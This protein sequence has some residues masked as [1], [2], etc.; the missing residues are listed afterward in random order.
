MIRAGGIIHAAGVVGFA[1]AFLVAPTRAQTSSIGARQARSAPPPTQARVPREEAPTRG[2]PALESRS[3]TAVKPQDPPTFAVNDLV[4]VIVREQRKFEADSDLKT[5]KEYDVSSVLDAF[6]KFTQGGTGAADFR[7]GKPT[8]DYEFTN[9]LR[10]QA[11]TSREDSLT[12]RITAGIIDVK[13]N[14]TLVLEA[15][16]TIQHEDEVSTMT[17]TG[18]CRKQDVTAD[19]TVLSTQLADAEIRVENDGALRD[20]ARRGWIPRLLDALRPF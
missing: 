4:T 20:T 10:G 12:T 13:P 5:K 11:D 7:R 16:R 19:N 6:I 17:L 1:F 2:N 9:E 8:I 15:R 18:L 3:W 14:G